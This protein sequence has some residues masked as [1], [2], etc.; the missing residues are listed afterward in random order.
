MHLVPLQGRRDHLAG[1]AHIAS[2]SGTSSC[3]KL[4]PATVVLKQP[5]Y[6]GDYS[7]G[8]LQQQASCAAPDVQAAPR[9][10]QEA[11]QPMTRA[12][13]AER[14]PEAQLEQLDRLM[15]QTFLAHGDA[16]QPAGSVALDRG[17]SR[18]S[19]APLSDSP[20]SL[21]WAAA[22]AGQALS[23]QPSTGT[24][25]GPA[26][27]GQPSTGPILG[28]ALSRQPSAEQP[29]AV[30]ASAQAPVSRQASAAAQVLSRQPSAMPEAMSRQPSTA[31]AVPSR[32]PSAVAPALAKQPSNTTSLHEQASA[33]AL[34]LSRG[35]SI[36]TTE[37]SLSRHRS[38]QPVAQPT[39]LP[40][41]AAANSPRP[42]LEQA[43]AA[44]LPALLAESSRQQPGAVL[45]TDSVAG[46]QVQQFDP[47]GE[48]M[49]TNGGQS[50]R[51]I[52]RTW[53]PLPHPKSSPGRL[54]LM[55]QN[56]RAEPDSARCGSCQCISHPLLLLNSSNVQ[57]T[58]QAG[59][60]AAA[61]FLRVLCFSI[62]TGI[63]GRGT[64]SDLKRQGACDSLL[65]RGAP[66]Q[67][68]TKMLIALRIGSWSIINRQR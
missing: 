15:Q 53:A 65:P 49:P 23:R 18:V 1:L 60:A 61:P 37:K 43:W 44:L 12:L 28:P 40:D 10:P 33:V 8:G 66:A 5:A 7:E 32:Q 67:D 36:A 11:L 57:Q 27:S 20:P 13:S 62:Q 52:L 59:M 54:T 38:A 39:L 31:A 42:G 29:S 58:A 51:D 46:P 17:V 19:T 64:P 2:S 68:S 22:S 4:Q 56:C 26:L 16:A 45:T 34:A 50:V 35:P 48:S 6:A 3:C 41:Q 30:Q 47:A 14:A 55:L 63:L 25:L 24:I 21:D 9:A